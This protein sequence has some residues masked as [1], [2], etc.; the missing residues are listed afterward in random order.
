MRVPD[1]P[2]ASRSRHAAAFE[3]ALKA[4][5]GEGAERQLTSPRR[6]HSSIAADVHMLANPA[7]D[8]GRGD[9]YD[10]IADTLAN[11]ADALQYLRR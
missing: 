11:G 2:S 4:V 9:N 5:H 10:F 7:D 1:S 3:A 8:H 6:S